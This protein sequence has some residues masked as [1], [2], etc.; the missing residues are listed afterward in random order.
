MNKLFTLITFLYISLNAIAQESTEYIR[1]N[2]I[3]FLPY[4]QK[5]AAVV[6]T[7]ATSF[8]IIDT[9]NNVVFSSS[10]GK[11]KVWVSSGETVRIADFS[12]LSTE[13]VYKLRVPE[14]GESFR[15]T[16][17]N[18]VF[19]NVNNA[20]VKAF[21]FNRASIELLEEF[22]GDYARPEG[23]P[24]TIV[25]I[26]PQAAGPV[27]VAGDTIKA[28]KGW[29]DAG[30]YNKYIVNSGITTGTLL[31]AYENYSNHFD[32]TQW[33]IPESSNNIADLLDE[34]KW[35]LDWMITMQ[36]PADGGVYNKTTDAKFG[37]MELPHVS[38]VTRYAVGKGTA[39]AY[40]FAAVMAKASR[41]YKNV[42]AIFADSC[43]QVAKKAWAWATSNPNKPFYNPSASGIYPAVSTGGYGD[44]NFGDEKLW[45]AAELLIATKDEDKYASSIPLNGSFDTPNWNS[46]GTMGLFTLYTNRAEIADIIDSNIVIARIVER[47]DILLDFQTNYNPYKV[48]ISNFNW[49]SNGDVA[50][51]GIIH[52]YAYNITNNQ[53]YY[54]AA[55]SSYDYIL[56]RNAT[57]YSFITGI[58][59]KSSQNIHHRPSEGDNIPGSVPGFLAGGPNKNAGDNCSGAYSSYSAKAYKDETCSFSTNEIA[60]NWQAP[61]TF[62]SH[63]VVAEYKKW[64]AGLPDQYAIL[65]QNKFGLDRTEESFSFSVTSNC[66]WKITT[67]D[68]WYNFSETTI[69]G[70]AMIDVTITEF[71][72]GDSIRNGSFNIMVNDE[73]V[74][75]AS[76]TQNGKLRN[77]RIEAEN[78]TD[79]LGVDIEN[80]LDTEG[81]KN[82]GWI[83]SKDYIIYTWDISYTGSYRIDYRTAANSSTGEFFVKIDDTVR[84]LVFPPKTGG[85]Q[86]WVTQSDTAYLTAGMHEATLYVYKGGFNLNYMDFTFLGEED[87]APV[88]QPTTISYVNNTNIY[89]PS[90]IYNNTILINGL[91]DSQDYCLAIYSIDGKL[92][93]K[94]AISSNNNS[95][96]MP[97]VNGTYNCVVSSKYETASFVIV[98]N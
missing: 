33:N 37:G 29:Y 7:D 55:L 30:D 73:V 41:V 78:F 19:T 65:N 86:K 54:N 21:Y 66:E 58:G 94:H 70:S 51:Q 82:V 14:Y 40:D 44:S 34:I 72:D 18:S 53:A 75:T 10:L 79:M 81:D 26:H 16:I 56:G 90:P 61:M 84:S 67:E 42:D 85:W 76:I 68:T 63:A 77:F 32:T 39:A 25:I 96:Q 49:G 8:E 35:N 83:D 57:E 38:P 59:A 17:S 60:I 91:E 31:Q 52:L 6:N 48:S 11:E 95:I 28:A 45:A 64:Q 71:N 47:A 80:T 15:F 50:N 69:V 36:D 92:L 2:Q 87:I 20:V 43:L 27:R 74:A 12:L 5:I 98:K 93:G 9:L 97:F 13:G 46:V 88:H 23:H 3:G 4:T 24:D 89:I 22:A 62:L 1:L